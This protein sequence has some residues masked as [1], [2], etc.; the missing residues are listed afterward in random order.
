MAVPK[1]RITKRRQGERRNTGHGKTKV[2]SLSSCSNCGYKAVK[3]HRACARCGF[4]KGKRAL[5]KLI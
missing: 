1:R 4:Y 3:I 2:M 5:A